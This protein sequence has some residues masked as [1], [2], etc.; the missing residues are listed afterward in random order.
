VAIDTRTHHVISFVGH[1]ILDV[2]WIAVEFIKDTGMLVVVYSSAAEH[3]NNEG[4]GTAV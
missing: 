1:A 3:T 4:I 2:S